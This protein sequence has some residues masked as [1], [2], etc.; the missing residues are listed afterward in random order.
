MEN[1]WRVETFA[2]FRLLDKLFELDRLMSQVHLYD[3]SAQM[4]WKG[5]DDESGLTVQIVW[6]APDTVFGASVGPG[7][8]DPIV[9]RSQQA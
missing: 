3:K 2:T 7:L 9:S 6:A 5:F 8:S 1:R 4:S